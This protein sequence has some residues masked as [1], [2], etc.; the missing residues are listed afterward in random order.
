MYTL[1]NKNIAADLKILSAICAT[2]FQLF[3]IAG[4]SRGTLA[5]PVYFKRFGEGFAHK[6]ICRLELF[7]L[8]YFTIIL[9]HAYVTSSL[10][11]TVVNSRSPDLP[12]LVKQFQNCTTSDTWPCVGFDNFNIEIE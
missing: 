11:L 12:N 3:R 5:K 2:F 8:V 4:R 1:Y 7:V 9:M 10:P 6:F